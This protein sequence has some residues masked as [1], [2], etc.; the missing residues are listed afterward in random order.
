MRETYRCWNHGGRVL[1]HAAQ[2]VSARPPVDDASVA[3][4][5]RG[6]AQGAHEPVDV[7]ARASGEE[8][9]AVSMT[10]ALA[11]AGHAL[12]TGDVPV[13]A[14]VVDPSGS[15]IGRGHN[16]REALQ[17]PTA[18]AELLALRSAAAALGSW[19]LDGCTLVVTLEPCAM[20]AGALVLARVARLVLGAWD[21]KAGAAG[22]M[23]DIV[24]DARL[25]HRVEVIGGVLAADA[26]E[27][28]RTFF[29]QR[30][31]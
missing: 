26:G 19:R 28:L 13:G 27:L 11:E 2:A 10:L 21:P 23:R 15:V 1:L 7:N 25:N 4:G 3:E 18:H 6:P 16:A 30:R 8:A 14:V 9:W 22:S 29:A 12:A 5:I 24:R 31:D 20:C 17:D